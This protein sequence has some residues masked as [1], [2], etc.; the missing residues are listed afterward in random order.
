MATKLDIDIER[1]AKRAYEAHSEE[2]SGT[3]AP[4]DYLTEAKRKAWREATIQVCLLLEG[5]TK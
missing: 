4:W 3:H 5:R 2:L 1:I